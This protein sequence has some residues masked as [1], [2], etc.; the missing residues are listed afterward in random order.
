MCVELHLILFCFVCCF[1]LFVL[2]TPCALPCLLMRAVCV[3]VWYGF[4]VLLRD[5]FAVLRF[6]VLGH[7][8]GGLMFTSHWWKTCDARYL[9]V[10]SFR[11]FT[12][13]FLSFR[14]R[15]KH[16]VS[17]SLSRFQINRVCLWAVEL[18]AGLWFM[19]KTILQLLTNPFTI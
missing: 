2:F 15:L 8:F 13:R 7:F 17:I 5:F 3:C 11:F 9:P 10:A 4:S 6:G 14:F 18:C 12:A 19:C 1:V 16:F